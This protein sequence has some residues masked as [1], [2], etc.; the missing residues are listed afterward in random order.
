VLFSGVMMSSVGTWSK[1]CRWEGVLVI[2][3]RLIL[4]VAARISRAV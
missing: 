4:S 1:W 2:R 3:N